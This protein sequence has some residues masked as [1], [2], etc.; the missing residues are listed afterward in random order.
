MAQETIFSKIIRQEIPADIVFQDDKVTAFRDI[1]PQ[2]PTHVLIIPNKLIPTVNDIQEEDEAILGH[3]MVV[4]A[5]IAKQ[6]GIDESGYRLIMNCNKDAGQEV[7][8]LHMHL[9]GGKNLGRL[10][11]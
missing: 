2:A 4:A 10:I 9:L 6:E 1:S 11:G 5:K 7:F 3:M 8:H